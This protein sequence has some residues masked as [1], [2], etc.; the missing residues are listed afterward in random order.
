MIGASLGSPQSVSLLALLMVVLIIHVHVDTTVLFMCHIYSYAL[1]EIPKASLKHK[2]CIF[3]CS[4][5]LLGYTPRL[6]EFHIPMDFIRKWLMIFCLW[7][8]MVCI[9]SNFHGTP[10]REESNKI[11]SL[12]NLFLLGVV[13]N[14]TDLMS[15][16][17]RGNVKEFNF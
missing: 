12:K 7:L 4:K 5:Y 17:C 8:G 6:L 13:Y 15:S 9:Y 3:C 14:I 2:E 1:G 11:G 10:S 16:S